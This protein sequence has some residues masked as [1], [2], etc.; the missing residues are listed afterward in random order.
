M[1]TPVLKSL[2]KK[3]GVSLDK[4]EELWDLA[5]EQ[6]AK[7]GR[8]DD[9]PYIIG[10]LKKMLNLESVAD[11]DQMISQVVEGVDPSKVL[12]FELTNR[13]IVNL[14]GVED[15]EVLMGSLLD[16]IRKVD[17]RCDV[18]LVED[19]EGSV[20]FPSNKFDKISRLLI[21]VGL[22]PTLSKRNPSDLELDGLTSSKLLLK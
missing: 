1:P 16:L 15:R 14:E 8:D 17:R 3:A 6:A 20:Y 5:K 19:T 7:R 12:E 13:V 21:N 4:A 9:W 2:A 10:I 18:E 11:I 22:G